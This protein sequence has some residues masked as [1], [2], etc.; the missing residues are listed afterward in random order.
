M[1]QPIVKIEQLSRIFRHGDSEVVALDRVSLEIAAGEFLALMGPSG[2]GKSTL[3]HAIAA[4]DRPT[5][6][7]CVVQG[8]DVTELSETALADWRNRHVGFVFQTFNLVPVLTAFENVEL[9]IGRAH[10]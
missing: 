10:V 3:L 2:S 1:T 7:T 4:I 5:S 8:T 6:G 9:Q